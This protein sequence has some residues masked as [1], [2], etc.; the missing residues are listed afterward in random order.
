MAKINFFFEKATA[1]EIFLGNSYQII[2][3]LFLLTN[4]LDSFTLIAETQ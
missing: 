1:V 4:I 3:F 2:L